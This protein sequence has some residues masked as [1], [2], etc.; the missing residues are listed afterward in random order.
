MDIGCGRGEFLE[1]LKEAGLPAVGVELNP[2]M[3]STARKKGLDVLEED[4]LEYLKGL[5]NLSLGGIFLSQVIEHLGPGILRELVRTAFFKLAPGGAL[6]AETI[7]PKC[8]TTFSGAFYLDLSHH[9][10]IHPEA[11]RFPMGI[12]RLSPS[13]DPVCL[14][15][16]PG[17][18]PGGDGSSG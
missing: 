8:L 17:N 15:L 4:G 13:G 5:P 16:S 12:P 14:T 10:P 2:E 9:N 18:A 11:A 7:N 1:I 3:V 6:I